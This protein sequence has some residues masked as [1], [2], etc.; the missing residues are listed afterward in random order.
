[1]DSKKEKTVVS[2]EEKAENGFTK[3]QLLAATR[4]S[5]RRD[6]LNAILEEDK[7][8][9]IAEVEKAMEECMRKKV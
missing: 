3:E 6:L 9:T 1:M 5:N 8:Y 4:F 7:K 2:K